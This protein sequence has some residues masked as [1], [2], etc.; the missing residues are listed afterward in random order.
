[1]L[2]VTDVEVFHRLTD[3]L[4]AT[5]DTAISPWMAPDEFQADS[6]LLARLLS[7]PLRQGKGQQ[8]GLFARAADAW[9]AHELRR[10][11]FGNNEV[12][13]RATRPRVLPQPLAAL[14]AELGPADRAALRKLVRGRSDARLLGAYYDKQVDVVVAD[15]DRGAELMVSTRSMLSSYKNNLH[16]RSED[17]VGDADNLRGRYPMASLGLLFVVRANIV[18]EA[19]ALPFVSDM[20]TRMRTQRLYDASGLIIADWDDA[21]VGTWTG[22]WDADELPGLLANP[23]MAHVRLDLIPD[24]LAP[25]RFFI[26]LIGAVLDRTPVEY[27]VDVRERRRGDINL[28]LGERE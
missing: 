16:N 18:E 23:E 5:A 28:G 6:E 24:E 9:V 2:D 8:S 1:M 7:V 4:L 26:D 3:H 27:H 19:G 10:A 25:S 14:E 12:W 15:W 20:L 17:L 11:G 22:Q 13:P 21:D